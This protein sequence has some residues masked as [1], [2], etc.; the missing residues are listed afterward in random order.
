MTKLALQDGCIEIATAMFLVTVT[1]TIIFLETVT[2]LW[3]WHCPIVK[4]QKPGIVKAL[5]RHKQT[6]L[7]TDCRLLAVCSP[8]VV[9]AP[10]AVSQITIRTVAFGNCKPFKICSIT[11]WNEKNEF[12]TIK[13]ALLLSALRLARPA[14]TAAWRGEARKAWEIREAE[15]GEI[16]E[17]DREGGKVWEAQGLLSLKHFH[18]LHG[19]FGDVA[20]GVV[21]QYF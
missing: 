4:L 10:S 3:L 11:F 2:N 15:A 1:A 12:Q 16:G 5:K 20:V 21:S 7:R 13:N 19:I 9:W 14:S 17:A 8:R 18:D 6:G